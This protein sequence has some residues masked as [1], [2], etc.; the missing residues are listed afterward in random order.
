VTILTAI[1]ANRLVAKHPVPV[2][3]L[4]CS[5]GDYIATTIFRPL[6]LQPP[7]S[8]SS[9]LGATPGPQLDRFLCL[10]SDF[11]FERIEKTRLRSTLQTRD[12]LTHMIVH[13]L[14]S[15]LTLVTG[16]VIYWNGWLLIN[17]IR[18]KQSVS[19][20]QNGRG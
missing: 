13:D 19:L 15:P 17:W 9:L 11:I 10:V 1:L 18:T 12:D 7:K 5:R 14:R 20:G 3:A 8:L 4:A 16:Y 6:V 2:A